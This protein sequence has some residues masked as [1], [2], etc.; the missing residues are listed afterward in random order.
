MMGINGFNVEL[1]GIKIGFYRDLIAFYRDLMQFYRDLIGFY[2]DLIGFYRV[3]F[4]KGFNGI[5]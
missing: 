4:F 1:M 5:L 3:F 2:R